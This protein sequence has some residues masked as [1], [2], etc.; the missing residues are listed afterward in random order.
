MRQTQGLGVD[1]VGSGSGGGNELLEEIGSDERGTTLIAT[2]RL[3]A[4]GF[5]I[6]VPLMVYGAPGLEGGN[7][8]VRDLEV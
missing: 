7:G 4:D 2:E 8:E 5:E 3:M 6:E 1:G